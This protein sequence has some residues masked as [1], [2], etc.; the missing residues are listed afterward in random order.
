MRVELKTRI[1][2]ILICIALLAC[3]DAHASLKAA[4]EFAAYDARFTPT[5]LNGKPV[6][7]RGIIT[8]RFVLR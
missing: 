5:L 7:V 8:Y 4:S 2:L 1:I 6:K 3:G